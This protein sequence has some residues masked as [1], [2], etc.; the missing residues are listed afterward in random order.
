[1]K[2]KKDEQ[3]G[4]TNQSINQ[5]VNHW[6]VWFLDEEGGPLSDDHGG[7]PDIPALDHLALAQVEGEPA[8]VQLVCRCR[9]RKYKEYTYF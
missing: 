7:Y 1:M 2:D 9:C 4:Y 6:C 5:A 8:Q 3:D